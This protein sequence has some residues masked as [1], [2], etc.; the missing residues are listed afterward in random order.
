MSEFF[1]YLDKIVENKEEVEL[2]YLTPQ[3]LHLLEDLQPSEILH[4]LHFYSQM[5]K[6]LDLKVHYCNIDIDPLE[7]VKQNTKV[8]MRN[9]AFLT[10]LKRG[11]KKIAKEDRLNVTLDNKKKKVLKLSSLSRLTSPHGKERDDKHHIL[12]PV[13][14]FKDLLRVKQARSNNV[15]LTRYILDI[16]REHSV[17]R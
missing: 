15:N 2:T 11:I 9:K 7:K 16:N 3:D 4:K 14:D 6:P 12:T 10:A 13:Q 8:H 5:K 1:R 17:S